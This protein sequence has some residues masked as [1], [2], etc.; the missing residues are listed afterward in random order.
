MDRRDAEKLAELYRGGM[1]TS[2]WVPDAAHEAL[3]DLL[4][5]VRTAA[6]RHETVAIAARGDRGSCVAVGRTTSSKSYEAEH[7]VASRPARLRQRLRARLSIGLLGR[8]RGLEAGA[9]D[10]CIDN[11]KQTPTIDEARSERDR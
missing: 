9:I 8:R 1:L 4:V 5:R 6:K 10:D 3:R 7:A 2:V 11:L